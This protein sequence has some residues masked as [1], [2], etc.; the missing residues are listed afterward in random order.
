MA[1]K[2]PAQK[3]PA[4]RK[5]IDAAP[6]MMDAVRAYV[7]GERKRN[8]SVDE[9]IA[10]AEQRLD[11]EDAKK[12]FEDH[13]ARATPGTVGAAKLVTAADA[14][15]DEDLLLDL[16]RRGF[17]EALR[18]HTLRRRI[19]DD[20]SDAL[21]HVANNQAA[22]TWS[23]KSDQY[24]DAWILAEFGDALAVNGVLLNDDDKVPPRPDDF[25]LT[26]HGGRVPTTEEIIDPRSI[27]RAVASSIGFPDG[28]QVVEEILRK[29]NPHGIPFSVGGETEV[30]MK[31]VADESDEELAV[32]A[33]NP[34]R[35]ARRT[36]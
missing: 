1:R 9:L 28:E 4:R 10:L 36:R 26:D 12:A 15:E 2:K 7:G 22:E 35:S 21:E 33:V 20:A 11:S 16:A 18:S 34:R 30:W 8:V 32:V 25:V 6:G 27:A 13:V 31:E 29:E 17:L 14:I 3:K 23:S 19:N 5:N 24:P